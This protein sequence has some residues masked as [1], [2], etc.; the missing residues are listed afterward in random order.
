MLL[1]QTAKGKNIKLESRIG[2]NVFIK[3]DK[4]MISATI[5]NIVSNALKFTNEGGNV[6][7]VAENTNGDV[8]IR[9]K[10]NG[11]GIKKEDLDKLFKLDAH[12]TT[13]G[14]NAEKG[15]GLGLII[16][17]E[18]VEKNG[19]TIKIVSSPGNGTEFKIKLPRALENAY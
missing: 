2:E 19:G 7:I 18:F 17:K 6:E 12:H 5:R 15:T 1:N 11:I 8:E 16:C 14:T 3:A 10:D 9:I 4:D 13:P